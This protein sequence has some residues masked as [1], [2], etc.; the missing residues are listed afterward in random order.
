ML[1]CVLGCRHDLPAEAGECAGSLTVRQ[2]VFVC[3]QQLI[4]LGILL[5]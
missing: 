4:Q 5:G 1:T 3:A 2:I